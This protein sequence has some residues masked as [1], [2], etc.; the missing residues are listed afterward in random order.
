MNF[1][2]DQINEIYDV[3]ECFANPLTKRLKMKDFVESLKI[4]GYITTQNHIMRTMTLINS[5]N[6]DPITFEEF[7][8]K[9]SEKIVIFFFH[10]I[11]Y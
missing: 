4:Y 3:F 1:T 8:T 9:L 2:P 5:E 6:E 7:L 10:L 11:L